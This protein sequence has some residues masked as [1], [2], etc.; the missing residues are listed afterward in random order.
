[1]RAM[2]AMILYAEGRFER[3]L[4]D[5]DRLIKENPESPETAPF[6]K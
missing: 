4:E 6:W 1:M 3:A 2:R 5:I